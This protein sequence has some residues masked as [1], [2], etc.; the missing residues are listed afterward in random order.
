MPWR[1]IDGA[2]LLEGTGLGADE[3]ASPNLHVNRGQE[4]RCFRNL[5]RC[6]GVQSIAVGYLSGID[7]FW[8]PIFLMPFA[9][10]GST[11]AYRIWNELPP[12]TKKYIDEHETK[13]AH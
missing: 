4:Q 12:A 5:L 6:S 3:V 9:L 2:A 13:K 10:V 7:W 11:I 1:R 8:W